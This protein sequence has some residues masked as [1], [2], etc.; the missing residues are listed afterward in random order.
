MQVSLAKGSLS[1]E[2]LNKVIAFF[3]GLNKP[4]FNKLYSL[5]DYVSLCSLVYVVRYHSYFW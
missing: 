5:H 1:C 2:I 3:N 4:F